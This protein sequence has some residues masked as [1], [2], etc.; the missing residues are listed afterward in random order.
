VVVAHGGNGAVDDA[1]VVP[2]DPNVLE[3]LGQVEDEPIPGFS[4]L[5]HLYNDPAIKVKLNHFLLMK[6]KLK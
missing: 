5:D 6:M 1:Q 2:L 3:R 4:C